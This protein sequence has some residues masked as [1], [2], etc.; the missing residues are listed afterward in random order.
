MEALESSK[1]FCFLCSACT[2]SGTRMIPTFS[3]GRV[4]QHAFEQ[5]QPLQAHEDVGVLRSGFQRV[6]EGFYFGKVGGTPRRGGRD[7]AAGGMLELG[8]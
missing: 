1:G 5:R 6:E 4:D 3:F 7:S 2:L 8:L